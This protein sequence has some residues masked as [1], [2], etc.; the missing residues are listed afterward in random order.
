MQ[1]KKNKKLTLEDLAF[2]MDR[3]FEILEKSQSKTGVLLEEL[4]VKFKLLLEGYGALDKRMD[5]MQARM[6]E[7]GSF[8]E[9]RHCRRKIGRH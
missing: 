3:R 2:R 4:D 9:I 6:D 8:Q 7:G 5:D 1:K